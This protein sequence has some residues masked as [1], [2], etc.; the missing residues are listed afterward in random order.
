MP[1]EPEEINPELDAEFAAFALQDDDDYI[2]EVP[3]KLTVTTGKPK[4]VD[5]ALRDAGTLDQEAD[6]FLRGLSEKEDEP[7]APVELPA[8]TV[9]ATRPAA[10]A[11]HAPW[12]QALA[13]GAA[14]GATA[15]F[16]D[17]AQGWLAEH[18]PQPADP[19][20]FERNYAAGSQAS[21]VTSS[22]RAADEEA[23]K[24]HPGAFIAGEAAGSA[25]A[26]MAATAALPVSGAAGAALVGGGTGALMGAGSAQEG[27]RL[28]GAV[29]GGA[30]GAVTGGALQGMSQGLNA[31]AEGAQPLANRLLTQVFMQPEQR[32]AL[33]ARKGP[34]ALSELGADARAAGLFKPES[35]LDYFRPATARRVANNAARVMEESGTGIK[36]FEQN[37]D[38]AGINPDVDVRPVAQSLREQAAQIERVPDLDASRTAKTFRKQADMLDQPSAE[39]V[40]GKVERPPAI[41]DWYKQPVVQTP[42]KPTPQQLEVFAQQPDVPAQFPMRPALE[43]EQ[44]SFATPRTMPDQQLSLDL[45]RPQPPKP[46]AQQLQMDLPR[47]MPDQQLAL[48]LGPTQGGLGFDQTRINRSQ[49]IDLGTRQESLFFGTEPVRPPAGFPEAPAP[50]PAKTP[51]QLD[52]GPQQT[53]FSM[54]RQPAPPRTAAPIPAQQLRLP[55]HQLSMR[56]PEPSAKPVVE[57]PWKPQGSEGEQQA[58]PLTNPNRGPQPEMSTPLNPAQAQIAREFMPL[59]E[60]MA[61]KRFMADRVNWQKRPNAKPESY[62]NESARKAVWGGMKDQIRSALENDPNVDKS[63]LLEYFKNNERFSTA[64]AAYDPALRLAERQ[65]QGGFGLTDL[66]TAAAVGGGPTGG[67]AAMASRA[68]T[69]MAPATAATAVRAGG[70]VSGAAGKALGAASKVSPSIIARQRQPKPSNEDVKKEVWY[71]QL[72]RKAGVLK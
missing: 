35:W 18:L 29:K 21:D 32:A 24:Q 3:E 72:G 23:R 10:P 61:T 33:Q 13:R 15:G 28:K 67:L 41:P 8:V 65:A 30:A 69:G 54:P 49:P 5:A 17:E 20:G 37:L 46:P 6:D 63:A 25:P 22:E 34:D 48:D 12:Y 58:L 9:E 1:P 40:T 26:A 43:G 16:G 53:S 62:G 66:A 70:A 4:T 31:V 60:A 44:L 14:Q 56:L 36:K 42:A 38:E 50:A 19:E 64:A 68:G 71:K 51:Q 47:Q 2:P 45:S 7:A 55:E 27:E 11:K 52:I 57:Q 59:N 39:V